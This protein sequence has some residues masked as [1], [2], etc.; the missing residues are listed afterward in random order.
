[1]TATTERSHVVQHSTDDDTAEAR[2]A[3]EAERDRHERI[4]AVR[5]VAGLATDAVEARE[6]Y[7]MLGLSHEEVREARRVVVAVPAGSAAADAGGR[8]RG[9]VTAA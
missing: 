5:V 3:K 6:L 4:A 2:Q 9:K 1:M 8:R 7:A